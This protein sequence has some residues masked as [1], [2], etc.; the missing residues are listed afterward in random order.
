MCVCV[1][2]LYTLWNL[3]IWIKKTRFLIPSPGLVVAKSFAISPWAAW[4]GF[5]GLAVL[6]FLVGCN[7]ETSITRKQTPV[8]RDLYISMSIFIIRDESGRKKKEMKLIV[9]RRRNCSISQNGYRLGLTPV[10]A[11]AI[12]HRVSQNN[13]IVAHY[14]RGNYIFDQP[15]HWEYCSM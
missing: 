9:F 1:L 12:H 14:S 2:Y 7:G 15:D 5:L 3:Y 13:D 4:G 11:N 6:Y 8:R 10:T